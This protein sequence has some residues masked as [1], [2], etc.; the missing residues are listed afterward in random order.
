MLIFR[1]SL[2]VFWEEPISPKGP[3]VTSQSRCHASYVAGVTD[4]AYGEIA[5]AV[6]ANIEP[7]RRIELTNPDS[8]L[9]APESHDLVGKESTDRP[10]Q[11]TEPLQDSLRVV[12]KD[13]VAGG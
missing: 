12:G 3:L 10:P 1:V 4:R 8:Y 9:H 11:S 5:D 6:A 2:D 7:L 13:E